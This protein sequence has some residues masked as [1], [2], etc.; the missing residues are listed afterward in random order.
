MRMSKLL[1]FYFSSGEVK[2]MVERHLRDNMD[3]SDWAEHL[4]KN[5]FSVEVN[6]AG[7]LV[8]SIDGEFE[9]K[10]LRKI[11]GVVEEVMPKSVLSTI[12]D[13]GKIAEEIKSVAKTAMVRERK[14][15]KR[16]V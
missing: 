14:R 16:K 4:S 8:V 7:E 11:R 1:T 6:K 13:A 3:R 9:E 12:E 5:E 15:T 10:G 2:S